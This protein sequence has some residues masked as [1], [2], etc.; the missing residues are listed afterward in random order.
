[1]ATPVAITGLGLVIVIMVAA[2]IFL[3]K[4]RSL[5]HSLP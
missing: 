4:E 3:R 1:M 5:Y 2:V